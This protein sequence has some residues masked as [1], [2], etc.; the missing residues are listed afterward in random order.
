MTQLISLVQTTTY[1]Y[2]PAGL[3]MPPIVWAVFT[4]LNKVHG[5]W[6]WYRRA[7]VYRKPENLANLAAGHIVNWLIGD[8]LIVRIAAQS[9]LVATRILDCAKQQAGL[10][11]AGRKWIDAIKGHYPAPVRI[12]WQKRLKLIHGIYCHLRQ[13]I[14]GR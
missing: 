6:R 8:M 4:G 7:D 5:L 3:R 13:C 12:E 1:D 2:T 10:F 9:L 14:G 11:R